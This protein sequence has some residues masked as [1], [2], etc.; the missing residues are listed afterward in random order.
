MGQHGGSSWGRRTRT[1]TQPGQSRWTCPLVEP[2]MEPSTGVE[3]VT[4]VWKTGMS[5]WTPRRHACPSPGSNGQPPVLHA[6]A[7]P[8]ELEGPGKSN[9][10]KPGFEPGTFALPRRRATRLR[11][12]PIPPGRRKRAPATGLS[13]MPS[14][15][16]FSRH[17]ATSVLGP[18][19]G[20]RTRTCSLRFWR[21]L[22]NLLSYT[23]RKK[24][25]PYNEKP[26]GPHA[27]WA[28]SG[29]AVAYRRHRWA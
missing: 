24:V 13:D 5:P 23:P 12:K 7:L 15:V 9:V 18:R 10:D 11:H 29:S 19:R 2:P 17:R 27:G 25:L 26:P 3:P 28:A 8:S 22:L 20:D 14:T 4:P 16:E 21:P 6:G 1:S